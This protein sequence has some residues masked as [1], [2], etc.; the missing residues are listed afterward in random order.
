MLEMEKDRKVES[1]NTKEIEEKQ[2]IIEELNTRVIEEERKTAELENK[3]TTA[4][5]LLG[6]L[7]GQVTEKDQEIKSLKL[8]LVNSQQ[9][10]RKCSEEIK[11]LMRTVEELQ[12][13][14]LKDSQLGTGTVRRVE[15]ETDRKS[16]V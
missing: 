2:A 8:E 13:R 9:N 4:D 14:N 5:E 6:Q 3:V 1:L 16:V 12:K 7:Q 10:E 15:Q 11:E